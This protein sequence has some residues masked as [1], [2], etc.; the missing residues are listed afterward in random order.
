MTNTYTAILEPDEDMMVALCPE[1]DVASQGKTIEEALAN[2]REAI[3][4]FLEHASEEELRA[5]THGPI[6]VT[7]V[8]VPARA[9]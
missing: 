2:L 8:E 9:S 3:G 1:L 6:M 4:L 7:Q 5:R